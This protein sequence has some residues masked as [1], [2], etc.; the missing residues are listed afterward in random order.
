M[1]RRGIFLLTI[2]LISVQVYGQSRTH[3]HDTIPQKDTLT[4]FEELLVIDTLDTDDKFTKVILYDDYTWAYFDLGRPV[5]DTSEF[6]DSW[7]GTGVHSFRDVKLSDLPE[8]V[9]LLLADSL[10]GFCVP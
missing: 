7:E 3:T 5:I 1:K 9:D 2:I 4:Y 10:N 6:F 8:E